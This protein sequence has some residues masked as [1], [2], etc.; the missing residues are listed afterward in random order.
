MKKAPPIS[1]CLVLYNEEAVI[2][3][4]LESLKDSVSEIIIVHDGECTDRTLDIA[5][6]YGAK[7]F[8]REHSGIAETHRVFSLEQA[9]Q[10]WCLCIDGDEFLTPELQDALS[11]LIDD[12]TVD[13]YEVIWP[14]WNGKREITHNW[15]YRPVLFRRSKMTYLAF[16]QEAGRT[17]GV[18]KKVAL[19]L[20]HQPDYDNFTLYRFR[21]KW[22]AWAKIQANDSLKSYND[23]SKFNLP[24]EG[25]WP[26][27]FRFVRDHPYLFPLVGLY[28]GLATLRDGGWKEGYPGWRQAL[29]WGSYNAAVY[30]YIMKIPR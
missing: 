27:K 21:T 6:K 7:I 9:T 23:I 2:E 5:K 4:C 15:P 26:A 30:Y 25:E 20:S 24:Q 19:T 10:E 8:I 1:A 3:R 22:L 17:T 16:P 18:S 11:T 12:S 29:M 13:L 28:T 14:L